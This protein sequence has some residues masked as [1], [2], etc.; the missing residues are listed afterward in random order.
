[1]SKSVG[2]EALTICWKK[3]NVFD[4]EAL[5]IWFLKDIDFYWR[6]PWNKFVKKLPALEVFEELYIKISLGVP[7]KFLK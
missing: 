1:M 6:Y 5:E 3:T 7:K 2:Q 4:Q